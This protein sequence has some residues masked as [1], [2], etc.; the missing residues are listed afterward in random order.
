M[1]FTDGYFR[2]NAPWQEMSV[3]N[4]RRYVHLNFIIGTEKI[5]RIIQF[6]ETAKRMHRF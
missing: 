1:D 2:N 4:R 3:P 6:L 5:I